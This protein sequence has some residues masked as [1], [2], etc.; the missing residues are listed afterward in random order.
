MP[1][2][3][4]RLLGGTGLTFSSRDG[5]FYI[6]KAATASITLGPVR[7]GGTVAHES[8]TGPGVG[9]V[10]T[11]TLT[12]SK[13]DTPII[14]MPNS[15]HVI[16]K[17]QMIDQQPQNVME[18]LRYNP[19]VHVEGLGSFA[20]GVGSGYNN[21]SIVQRGFATAQFVDGIRSY[22]NSAG[23]TAFL[24]RIEVMNGPASVLYGQTTPGGLIGMSLKSRPTH[25]CAT[26]PLALA[27]GAGTRP[28][29]MS[30]T[31]SRNQGMCATALPVLA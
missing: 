22:S 26:S 13:I 19:G 23:E 16:T 9:Y 14:E 28:R 5:A 17:Q 10:A 18:A 20:N 27:T 29:S 15:I 12:G 11:N 1:D 24:E 21:G 4:G 6:Q 2:A 3:I 8:A 30:A 7:V 25:R 31:G